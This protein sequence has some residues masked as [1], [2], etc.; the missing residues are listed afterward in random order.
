MFDDLCNTLVKGTICINVIIT[1]MNLINVLND[2]NILLFILNI[3]TIAGAILL[4]MKKFLGYFLFF[5]KNFFNIGSLLLLRDLFLEAGLSAVEE[6][7][8]I[9]IFTWVIGPVVMFLLI[10][11]DWDEY[12]FV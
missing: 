4:W 1:V 3:L 7:I 5:V 11:R 8:P 6:L 12:R 9:I 2:F 10:R